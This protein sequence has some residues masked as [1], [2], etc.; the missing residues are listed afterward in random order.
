MRNK[1]TQLIFFIALLAAISMAFVYRELFNP[2]AIEAWITRVGFAGP[3]VFMLIYALGTVLFLPGSLLTLS[4]GA[5]FGPITGTLYNL[6]GATLGATLSF[7]IARYLASDWI[8][9][10]TTG[11]LKQL[12]SGVESE[13]W[14]FVAFVRL[15]PLFP[16][17]LLNYALGL[18]RIKLWHY[19]ITSY[20][21]MLPGAMAYTY[22][23]Y[24]GREALTGSEDLIEHGLLALTLLAVTFFLPRLVKRIRQQTTIDV[25]TL[26]KRLDA[27]ED[28]LIIDV[29][30][31]NEFS[32]EQGH[33]PSAINIPLDQLTQRIDEVGS[34]QNRPIVLICL[35][36]KRSKKALTLLLTRGFENT[37]VAK[38]GMLKWNQHSFM[39]E[40]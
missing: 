6:S 35:S 40:H 13:G 22:L 3:L 38:G 26:K 20:I 17:N 2:A 23:G 29:R 25:T 12:K 18:T 10:K 37:V 1:L 32:A 16:F 39:V 19:I 8:Q 24:A 11:R 7:L 15:I 33:I 4:G 14:R 9:Q 27:G 21:S 34:E 5:L 31:P 28:V 30:E 36:D